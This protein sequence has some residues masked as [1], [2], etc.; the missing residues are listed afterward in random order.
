MQADAA[1]GGG[2]LPVNLIL[3]VAMFAVFYFFLIRPQSR[4]AK[5]QREFIA[6]IQKGQKVVTAGGIHGKIVEVDETNNTVLVQ[7]DDNTK[8]RIEKSML[9]TEM[10]KAIEAARK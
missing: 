3:M 6:S 7:V 8:L 10:T 5:E 2:G 1:P 9:S 4:K